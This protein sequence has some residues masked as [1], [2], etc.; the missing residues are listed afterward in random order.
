MSGVRAWEGVHPHSCFNPN[1]ATSSFYILM[2]HIK[3]HLKVGQGVS[4]RTVLTTPPQ[5]RV[6]VL[7]SGLCFCWPLTVTWVLVAVPFLD[8]WCP[9]GSNSSPSRGFPDGP[10]H[11]SSPNL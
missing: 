8:S 7:S 5:P 6:R 3:L 2:S 1:N 11:P 9:S 10:A 4:R